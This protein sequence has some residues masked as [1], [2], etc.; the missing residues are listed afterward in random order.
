MSEASD[1]AGQRC[2]L[3]DRGLNGHILI[4]P[5]GRR[6]CRQ[7]LPAVSLCRYCQHAFLHTERS[8]SCTSCRAR[9]V[10]TEAEAQKLV[11]MGPLSWFEGHRLAIGDGARSV[12]LAHRMPAHPSGREMFGY[13]EGTQVVI[14]HALPAPVFMLVAAHE[15]GHLWL[16]Q[17]NARLSE[18][19]EE[20][21]CDW[22]S[23]RFARDLSHPEYRWLARMIARRSETGAATAF[24][25]V[26]ARLGHAEPSELPTLLP[27]F[28]RR[29]L[30]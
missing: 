27:M 23:W 13:V 14:R 2:C 8:D 20:G 4:D 18:A 5:R 17:T 22:L 30:N 21:I 1:S 10:T 12:R 11:A 15:L 6:F 9:A 28:R 24:R 7:H 19:H 29:V 25:E 3:C 26:R 16:S